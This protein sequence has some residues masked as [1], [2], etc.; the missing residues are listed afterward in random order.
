MKRIALNV[1]Q[2]FVGGKVGHIL[3]AKSP[4]TRAEFEEVKR[5]VEMGTKP[6]SEPRI[7]HK[8]L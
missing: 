4:M 5:R 2:V 8:G 7:G 6:V 1:E 3:V